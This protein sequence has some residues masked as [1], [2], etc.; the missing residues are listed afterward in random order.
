MNC[1]DCQEPMDCCRDCDQP[2]EPVL[3][4][5]DIALIDGTYTNAT[6]TVEKGCITSVEKGKAPL[7]TPD[8]CCEPITVTRSAGSSDFDEPCDC[9]P[10][11]KGDNATIAIG[12]IQTI[13]EG[14][15]A[16]VENSGTK[17]NAILDFYLPKGDQ[18]S[19][20]MS[21]NGVTSD[22]G[23]LSIENGL[24]TALPVAWPPVGLIEAS[25]ETPGVILTASNPDP[26]TGMVT[27]K[28]D[29]KGLVDQLT[30]K[31]TKELDDLQRA[32]ET[33]INTLESKVSKL[34]GRSSSLTGL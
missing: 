18:G 10:G 26:T 32:M 19:S 13:G 3:P 33:R 22:K 20:G 34:E 29:V 17:T 9:P 31:F 7:Y 15:P 1:N 25:S 5:C 23:G 6:I 28:V 16:R 14:E 8:L 4:R 30:D 21:A 11:E 12:K 24:I 2:P 27:L